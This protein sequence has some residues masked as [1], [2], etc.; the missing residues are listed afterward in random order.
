MD[1]L[2]QAKSGMGK[3]AVFVLA[4]LQQLE[5][6]DGQVRHSS[7]PVCLP[8]RIFTVCSFSCSRVFLFAFFLFVHPPVG[9]SSCSHCLCTCVF[10]CLSSGFF[11]SLFV[12]NIDNT[13]LALI[14]YLICWWKYLIRCKL[15]CT[16]ALFGMRTLK[17][18]TPITSYLGKAWEC[19]VTF[20]LLS[21]DRVGWMTRL[22]KFFSRIRQ[23]SNNLYNMPWWVDGCQTKA[24]QYDTQRCVL[25]RDFGGIY[26][27]SLKFLRPNAR[28]SSSIK[29]FS[30][31]FMESSYSTCS[32][33]LREKLC[34]RAILPISSSTRI[35]SCVCLAL[36]V[37]YCLLT[38]RHVPFPVILNCV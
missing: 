30:S 25:T 19:K 14:D 35:G 12:W 34:L 10:V 24:M 11:Q 21:N 33:C 37:S 31:A 3:T 4:T 18:S 32:T 27:T 38:G 5:P 7:L 16:A 20:T 23:S 28:L 15:S 6:V 29:W 8:V 13:L 26:E 2:C 1:I 22:I 36:C 17:V 9:V